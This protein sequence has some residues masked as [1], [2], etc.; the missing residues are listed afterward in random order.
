M[1]LRQMDPG[2]KDDF[3]IN[4]F[5][6]MFRDLNNKILCPRFLGRMCQDFDWDY[7]KV[8]SIA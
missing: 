3:E 5:V 4:S 8:F 6:E 1:Q 2:L 7:Q